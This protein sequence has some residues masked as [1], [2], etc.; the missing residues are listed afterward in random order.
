MIKL[1]RQ[2]VL[3]VVKYLNHDA[4]AAE[5]SLRDHNMDLVQIM[6]SLASTMRLPRTMRPIAA[7][8]M[9]TGAYIALRA[10]EK[11]NV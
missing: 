7:T 2:A 5:E 1:D 3:D 8:L 11:K 9:V 10:A 6:A 4:A